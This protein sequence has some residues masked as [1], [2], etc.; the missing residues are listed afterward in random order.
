MEWLHRYSSNFHVFHGD[1]DFDSRVE[2][3]ETVHCE[4]GIGTGEGLLTVVDNVRQDTANEGLFSWVG[5][6]YLED[7]VSC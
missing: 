3:G 5:L 7:S 2:T 1:T 4:T 6:D